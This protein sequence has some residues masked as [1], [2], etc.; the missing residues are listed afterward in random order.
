MWLILMRLFLLIHVFDINLD[1]ELP[2]YLGT[3]ILDR[4]PILNPVP[5][6]RYNK[7]LNREAVRG[8]NTLA[9]TGNNI[10]N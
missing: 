9:Y 6:Y 8:Y 1:K 3:T 5:D 7:Y 4:N 10:I 2:S